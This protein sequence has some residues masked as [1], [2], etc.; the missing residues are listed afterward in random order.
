MV[1]PIL[2]PLKIKLTKKCQRCGLRY[3]RKE[4]ECS[5]CKNLTDR[6]VENLRAKMEEEHESNKNMGRLFMYI[7]LLLLAFMVAYVLTT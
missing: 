7:S 1:G 4:K 5:H 3:P 6:E 2:F